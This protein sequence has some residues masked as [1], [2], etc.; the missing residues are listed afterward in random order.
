MHGFVR[1]RDGAI[2]ACN[3]PGAGMGASQGAQPEFTTRHGRPPIRPSFRAFSS[4]AFVRSASRTRSCWEIQAEIAIINSP[5]EPVAQQPKQSEHDI[6]I[7]SGV[8]HD[9]CRV[10][11]RLLLQHHGE[12]IQAVAQRSGNHDRVQPRELIRDQIFFIN[13]TSLRLE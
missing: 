8:G 1:A 3:A 7:C 12:T 2:T 6:L 13:L 5:A 4:P 11:Y 9:L 10:K